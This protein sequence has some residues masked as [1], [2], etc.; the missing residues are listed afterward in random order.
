MIWKNKF[1]LVKFGFDKDYLMG[2]VK[3]FKDDKICFIIV[4]EMKDVVE[5]FYDD[6]I[7]VE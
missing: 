2:I 6:I 4:D 3:V 7:K 5:L 1:L